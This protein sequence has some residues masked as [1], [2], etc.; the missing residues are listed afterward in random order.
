[1]SKPL[2]YPGF[3]NHSF[4]IHTPNLAIS[5]LREAVV[6]LQDR[7]DVLRMRLQIRGNRHVQAFDANAT[8]VQLIELDV[9]QFGSKQNLIQN[10]LSL[11]FHFN[12][13]SGPLMAVVYLHGFK[14][15]SARI[16]FALH[17]MLVDTVSWKIIVSDLQALYQRENLDLKSSSV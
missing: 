12:L 17:H 4:I 14:D 5:Q 10:L 16:F 13:E 11:Q 8:P 9:S 1:M 2:R 3:W 7:H 15:G 6:L